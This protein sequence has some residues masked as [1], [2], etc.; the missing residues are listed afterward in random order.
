MR[1]LFLDCDG[2]LNNRDSWNTI[3]DTEIYY[4]CHVLNRDLVERL[5]KIVKDTDCKVVLS[6]TWRILDRGVPFLKNN[7]IDIFDSTDKEYGTRGTQIARWLAKH[8]EVSTYAIVDDDDDMLDSQLKHFFQTDIE[9]GL[10]ESVAYRITYWLTRYDKE[11]S[12][13]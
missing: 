7:G 12:K 4:S 1:V 5:I 8:P 13:N 11:I 3:Y 9:H 2:V 10:T 6:S